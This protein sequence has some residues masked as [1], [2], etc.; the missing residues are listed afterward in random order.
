MYF[1]TVLDKWLFG[2]ILSYT[3]TQ[4]FQFGVSWEP[5]GVKGYKYIS[6]YFQTFRGVEN[7][8]LCVSFLKLLNPWAD[9]PQ[10]LEKA[11]ALLF[12]ALHMNL[13]WVLATLQ[14]IML[15]TAK[16]ICFRR[17]LLLF[18]PKEEY[19]LHG[20]IGQIW[21]LHCHLPLTSRGRLRI[22]PKHFHPFL[23][24]RSHIHQVVT[25]SSPYLLLKQASGFLMKKIQ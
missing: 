9:V 14:R 23:I 13:Y 2:D 3:L 20:G 10:P 21:F 17:F 22:L 18:H 6:N 24:Q 8:D 15:P 7:E 4:C 25:S 12:S 19:F 11:S 5:I 16:N 1:L